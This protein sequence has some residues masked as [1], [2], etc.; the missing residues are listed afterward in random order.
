MLIKLEDINN[1]AAKLMFVGPRSRQ[2]SATSVV[3]LDAR[4]LLACSL[5]GQR[6][7]LIEFNA[8]RGTHKVLSS[9][10][11]QFAGRPMMT[12]LM[13]YDG[14]EFIVTSDCGKCAVSL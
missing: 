2:A 14:R 10:T 13:D 11:T 3:L 4:R 1:R 7:Y 6:M 5:A 12:D 8:A 9:V